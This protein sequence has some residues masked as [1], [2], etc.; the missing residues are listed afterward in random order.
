MQSFS[1]CVCVRVR[2]GDHVLVISRP[3]AVRDTLAALDAVS[4]A[5]A[6]VATVRTASISRTRL[7]QHHSALEFSQC[8]SYPESS[9]KSLFFS[10]F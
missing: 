8:K 1:H 5:T 3:Q 4:H 6:K 7:E 2:N 10:L 9:K